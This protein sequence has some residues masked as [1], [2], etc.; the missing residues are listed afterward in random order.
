MKPSN[1]PPPSQSDS[2]LPPA[3]W[4]AYAL[5]AGIVLLGF[6][7]VYSFFLTAHPRS[8]VQPPARSF[9]FA[10]EEQAE[11]RRLAVRTF[12]QDD[13]ALLGA[14][15]RMYQEKDFE[16][17]AD[18]ARTAND[19]QKVFC[20]AVMAAYQND[21]QL[22]KMQE[23][24]RQGEKALMLPC[25]L[26]A[27]RQDVISFLVEC[28]VGS[29]QPL[30][31]LSLSCLKAFPSFGPEDSTDNLQLWWQRN[32]GSYTIDKPPS[33]VFA[34][35][36][37]RR[38]AKAR[39][40]DFD[41]WHILQAV[42]DYSILRSYTDSEF[43]N[44]QVLRALLDDKTENTL[45]LNQRNITQF[46]LRQENAL[47]ELVINERLGRKSQ[48]AK[49]LA[50]SSSLVVVSPVLQTYLMR[51]HDAEPVFAADTRCAQVLL[52]TDMNLLQWK[53]KIIFAIRQIVEKRYF[54]L[55]K[56]SD[57]YG[58]YL[59]G[60]LTPQAELRGMEFP[61]ASA[62]SSKMFYFLMMCDAGIGEPGMAAILER[63]CL[64]D[65]GNSAWPLLQIVLSGHQKPTAAQW[66]QLT[67]TRAQMP[68]VWYLEQM[69]D[70]V[71]DAADAD[72]L[73]GAMLRFAARND[74]EKRLC[75]LWKLL[76]EKILAACIDAA[77]D[78]SAALEGWNLFERIFHHNLQSINSL[79]LRVKMLTS[80][81]EY[82]RKKL[83]Q[84]ARKFLH[85]ARNDLE[86]Y[87]ELLA[88]QIR[89]CTPM[90]PD[91]VILEEYF[92]NRSDDSLTYA[93][94]I[95]AIPYRPELWHD[96]E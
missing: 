63:C 43:A 7:I 4:L 19:A 58:Y 73:P 40:C 27:P 56:S 52:K 22:Q 79:D 53:K 6:G 85:R 50:V 70:N 15:D 42:Q 57:L 25:L 47:L 48:L 23:Q 12:G 96:E 10:E 54:A 32:C 86:F 68:P 34:A 35:Y 3:Q 77:G 21:T 38:Q 17:L 9:S 60:R 95:A 87:R 5:V 80:V 90:I 16:T 81:Q 14:L 64:A 78:K 75:M 13:S 55:S 37:C 20:W 84:A 46:G 93:S 24:I 44:F 49:Q 89:D 30:R 61:T 29:A 76:Y 82:D 39:G 65:P 18:Y 41:Y 59:P 11:L 51:R 31:L 62:P 71:R 36:S 26:L 69:C 8:V 1:Q 94:R 91:P 83:H 74:L 28:A 88:R 45:A 92:R 72:K 66:A 33:L 67:G 2:N